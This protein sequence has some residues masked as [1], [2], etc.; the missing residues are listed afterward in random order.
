MALRV[1]QRGRRLARVSASGVQEVPE[2]RPRFFRYFST[3]R[4]DLRSLPDN[5]AS[6]AVE[7]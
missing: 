2:D 4:R 6:E 5:E 7:A 1:R 3:L